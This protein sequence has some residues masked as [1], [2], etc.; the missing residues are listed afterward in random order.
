MAKIEEVSNELFSKFQRLVPL[1]NNASGKKAARQSET[2][3]SEALNRFYAEAKMLRIEYKLGIIARA[4]IARG[5]QNRM[6]SAG[7]SP[8]LAYRVVFS[9]LLSA[10]VGSG[11]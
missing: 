11:K 5:V 7:Y 3:I 2:Q 9:L 1:P 4:R 6:I 10:F 8:D